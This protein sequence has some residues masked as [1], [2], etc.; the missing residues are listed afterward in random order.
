MFTFIESTVFSNGNVNVPQ[1]LTLDGESSPMPKDGI[2]V[3]FV[4]HGQ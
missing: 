4:R 2:R 3:R 1:D